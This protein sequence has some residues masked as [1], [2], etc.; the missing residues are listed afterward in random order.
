[1]NYAVEATTRSK[2]P[3]G[4]LELVIINTI[5]DMPA[6]VIA[7]LGR[8]GFISAMGGWASIVIRPVLKRKI[9]LSLR[10]GIGHLQDNFF[11]HN[12]VCSSIQTCK[13]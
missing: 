13:N 12:Q 8:G 6:E 2:P 3:I 1:M 4:Y 9:S 11:I 10:T 5:D 7:I